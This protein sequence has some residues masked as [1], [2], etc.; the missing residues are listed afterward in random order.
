MASKPSKTQSAPSGQGLFN[1]PGLLGRLIE[2]NVRLILEQELARHLGAQSYQRTKERQ[3]YRNGVKPRSMHTAVGK[4]TL[5]VPQTRDGSFHPSVFERYQ[6]SDKAL[7][8]AMQ[9]MVIQGVSTRKV[10]AVLE[11]MAGFE[12]SAT[13]VSRA[14]V[15][16]EEEIERFRQRRLDECEWPYLIID[17]RYEKVRQGGRVIS[18]A[19]LVAA[20][21][22]DQGRRE[23]VG[24]AVGDSESEATWSG[25]FTAL[26]RRGLAGV[27]LVVSDAHGGIR[28]A[29]ARHFQGAAWQRC[30]VHLMRELLAKVNW[31]D[32]YELAAD[33]KAIYVGPSAAQCRRVAGEV[34][35]KWLQRAPK[36]VAALE[37][38]LE[39][40]LTVQELAPEMRRRLK[41][42]NLLERLMRTL[43]QRTKVVLIFPSV[44]SLDRLIGAL[45]LEK[46][47]DWLAEPNRYLVLER[48]G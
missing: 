10:A 21:I 17:A 4:L 13:T 23:I 46:Q 12:L 41:S 20:A 42:T 18:Q 34:A 37:A 47:E 5:Q 25:L 26:K 31:R 8:A 9:E 38:G 27:E 44:A 48:Q 33:L 40:T 35:E 11:E 22:N 30:R 36:M 6:R 2:D 3:G 24:W 43:K 29:L 39:D 1:E 19:V 32:Y 45:L 15:T 14:C 7:V 28:A 16:M